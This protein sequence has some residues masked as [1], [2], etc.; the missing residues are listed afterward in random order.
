MNKSSP[1]K[2]NRLPLYALY[3]ADVISVSGNMMAF[4]AIP[5][6]VLQTTG[7]ASKTGLTAFVTAL[8]AVIAG[9]FGGVIIDRI[10]YKR[11]SVI[12]D[13]SSGIA[14]AML[15]LLF[16]TVG[17]AFWQLLVLV[18]LGNIL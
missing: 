7:S 11:T 5:W 13:L 2:R 4:I 6:F 15:P 18:F 10:G 14:V 8:P 9:F 16:N 3:A 17:L 1:Q 12:A